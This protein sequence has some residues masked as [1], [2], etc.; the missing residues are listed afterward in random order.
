MGSDK[1]ST[2]LVGSCEGQDRVNTSASIFA[3]ERQALHADGSPRVRMKFPPA[4][5]Q[6]F[7]LLNI[8]VGPIY[9]FQSSN[10]IHIGREIDFASGNRQDEYFWLSFCVSPTFSL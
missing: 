2:S 9:I 3:F 6:K 7:P 5:G 1:I 10:G 8:S 4:L